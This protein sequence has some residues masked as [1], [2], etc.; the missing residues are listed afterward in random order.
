ME[1]KFITLSD[2]TALQEKINSNTSKLETIITA[3]K[4]ENIKDI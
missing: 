3:I 4:K 1:E 2:Y